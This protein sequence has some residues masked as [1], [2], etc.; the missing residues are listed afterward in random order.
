MKGNT[1]LDLKV[2][3]LSETS[4]AGYEFELVWPPTGERT[5][6]FVKVRG[7]ESKVARAYARK[8]YTEYRQKEITA[9]RKGR[10]EEMS[11]EDAEDMAI[12]SCITRIISWRGLGEAGTEV[13]FTK[14]NAERILREH[15]WI[16]T[17]VMNASDELLN[18]Q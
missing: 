1:M 14:E 13:P 10:E 16:R 5:G 6:A 2:K 11:L 9:K 4:E 18:F 8:K 17:E 7:A 12:E 15:S 3:N